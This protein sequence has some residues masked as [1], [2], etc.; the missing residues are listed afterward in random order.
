MKRTPKFAAAGLARRAF[1]LLKQSL[2]SIAMVGLLATQAYADEK[3]VVTVTV[4]PAVQAQLNKASPDERKKMEAAISVANKF[5]PH[6]FDGSAYE[7]GDSGVEQELK[8]WLKNV[9]P[10]VNRDVT[11]WYSN[12]DISQITA[13]ALKIDGLPNGLSGA[14]VAVCS[15]IELISIT[16]TD[17]HYDVIWKTYYPVSFANDSFVLKYRAKIIGT[18]GLWKQPPTEFFP[19]KEN[20]FFA[21]LISLDKEYK[22]NQVIPQYGLT[23]LNTKRYIDTLNRYI[24]GVWAGNA[25]AADK[26]KLWQLIPKIKDAEARVCAST[27]AVTKQPSIKE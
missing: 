3:D 9:R 14:D 12:F 13:G 26:T 17:E 23:T 27:A 22:V 11:K 2:L 24:S 16:P 7:V 15:Q 20:Q 6:H 8:Y 4:S 19:D 10:L 18:L 5:V 1:E 21:T 25:T